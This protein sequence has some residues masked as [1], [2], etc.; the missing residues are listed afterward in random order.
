MDDFLVFDEFGQFVLDGIVSRVAPVLQQARIEEDRG[1]GTNGGN[2]STALRMACDDLF[3]VR[4]LAQRGDA[5]T[6][7]NNQN[8]EKPVTKVS[9]ILLGKHLDLV[10]SRYGEVLADSDRRYLNSRASQQVDWCDG[11]HFLHSVDKQHECGGFF[12]LHVRVMTETRARDKTSGWRPGANYPLTN[13]MA[14]D[15]KKLLIFGCGYIG[16]AVAAVARKRGWEVTALTRNHDKARMLAD[17]GCRVVEADLADLSWHSRVSHDQSYILNSVSSGGQGLEGYRHSYVEGTRS[18]LKWA[19]GRVPAT[20]VY[21]GSTSVYPQHSGERVDEASEVG[22]GSA[23]SGPLLQ[24]EDLVRS[25]ECFARWF[26]LRIAGIYGPGR[27]Y[28]L[29]QLR[30]GATEFPGTATHRLNLAF[31]EDI[32]S[33]IMACFDAVEGIRNCVFNVSGD[34]AISKREV[35]DWLA[36]TLGLAPPVFVG[37]SPGKVHENS[38]RRG[39]SGPVPDRVIANDRIKETLGWRPR[40]PDFRDGYRRIFEIETTPASADSGQMP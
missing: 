20:Y 19:Q 36:G 32:V 24:A 4:R 14:D 34:T 11:F 17:S 37:D 15:Q 23:A 16:S 12:L 29:D 13:P 40:F 39:R 28:L 38:S 27:H 26:L 33:A 18:I 10:A 22:G 5:G 21:T 25:S 2:E 7:G 35:V 8:V 6:A 9:Q 31:R 1:R 3:Y 30:S